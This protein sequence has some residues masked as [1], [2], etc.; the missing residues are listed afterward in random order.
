MTDN[1]QLTPLKR[2]NEYMSPFFKKATLFVLIPAVLLIIGL[3]F[4]DLFQGEMDGEGFFT[5]IGFLAFLIV[6]IFIALY[7]KKTEKVGKNIKD[8]LSPTFEKADK[9]TEEVVVPTI[10]KFILLCLG[11]LFTVACLYGL[12]ALVR[13]LIY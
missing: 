6:P 5:I 13:F 10:G 8:K 12:R 2:G 9:Y 11:I 4:I 3:F 1:I 7:P